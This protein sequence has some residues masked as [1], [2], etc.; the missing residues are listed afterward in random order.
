MKRIGYNK[1]FLAAFALVTVASSAMAATPA[2]NGIYAP[3]NFV[4]LW[5]DYPQAT[6]TLANSYPSSVVWTCDVPFAATGW[7]EKGIFQLSADGG[8]SQALF[9]NLSNFS[10]EADFALSGTN[11]AHAEGGIMVSPWWSDDSG[12]LMANTSGEITFWGSTLPFYS[13]SG[14][15]AISYTLGAQMHQKITYAAGV[16]EPTELNPAKAE[17]SI[18][19]GG[20]PYTSGLLDVMTVANPNDPPPH[21]VGVG[22]LDGAKVGGSVMGGPVMGGNGAGTLV[23]TFGNVNFQN[24]DHPTAARTTSWGAMKSLYR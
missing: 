9:P 21:N 24:Q 3:A 6:V 7:A 12:V 15:Y 17:I 11:V 20:T 2:I 5:N 19:Y 4:R 13:F 16:S 22:L 18:I 10:Y 8:A 23:G 1:M 14:T